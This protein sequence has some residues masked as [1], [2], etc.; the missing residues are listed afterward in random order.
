MNKRDLVEQS[1]QPTNVFGQIPG[2]VWFIIAVIIFCWLMDNGGQ[3]FITNL[4]AGCAY[5]SEEYRPRG[6][7]RGGDTW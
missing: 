7:T 3:R 2:L 4:P 5:D 6:K 1:Q